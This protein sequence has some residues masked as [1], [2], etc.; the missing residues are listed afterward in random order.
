VDNRSVTTSFVRLGPVELAE[1]ARRIDQAQVMSTE[2]AR[3]WLEHDGRELLTEVMFLRQER[4]EAL[5]AFNEH[6]Q[7]Q[8]DDSVLLSEVARRW[9]ETATGFWEKAR[10]KKLVA[11][12]DEAKQDA[13]NW[14]KM[15]DDA[16]A[17]LS[18]LTA[19][20][21]A[22]SE[23]LAKEKIEL[24]MQVEQITN[25][26]D[27]YIERIRETGEELLRIRAQLQEAEAEAGRKIMAADVDA[28]AWKA[29]VRSL[30]AQATELV[31]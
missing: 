28:N 19:K 6:S 17:S 16:M 12:R 20:H 26:R 29:E 3:A 11:E 30:L 2:A 23:Q 24:A 8:Y 31:S 13:E 4:A 25:D 21:A 22:A 18:D 5:D 15:F 9:Q 27:R 7:D 1:K 14:Q 10:T